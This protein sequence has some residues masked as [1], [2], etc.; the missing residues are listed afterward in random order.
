MTAP[1]PSP[2]ISVLLVD[3]DE[4]DRLALK[5]ALARAELG[6]VDIVEADKAS[7]AFDAIASRSFDCAFF[8]YRLPDD[9]GVQLLRRV[10]AAGARTP[11]VLLTGFGDEQIVLDAMKAGANDYLAK[12]AVSPERIGQAVR[13]ALRLRAAER[14][15]EIAHEAQ[16]RNAEQLRRLADAA[17][18]VNSAA[19]TSAMLQTAAIHACLITSAAAATVRLSPEAAEDLGASNATTSWY[20]ASGE[21]VAACAEL[22][23]S[24]PLPGRGGADVGELML[25][26]WPKPDDDAVIVGQLARLL[27][28][29]LEN[30]RLYEAAQRATRARDD[31]LA[32]VSHDLRNPLH[33]ISLSSSFLAEILGDD[34]AAVARQQ[35]EI[36]RRAVDRA[37]NL[38][39]DL[40]DVSRMDAGM[41]SVDAKATDP[42]GL[43]DEVIE[44][45]QPVAAESGVALERGSQAE[46][47]VMADHGRA[48]QVFMNLV[49]NAIK[50]TRRGGSVTLSS[51]LTRDHS[52]CFA[53]RDT[54]VGISAENLPHIFDRFWQARN[55][56]RAGAGLGLAIAK[57]IVEAHGGSIDVSSAPGDGTEFSFTLPVA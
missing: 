39:Q 22:S 57:G 49:G 45:M 5:R 37:N 17:V 30:V 54:G 8:D 41:F 7:V 33:T 9:D 3:D 48:L 12:S 55:A 53:V 21:C 52:V 46:A 29:A 50:F 14:H 13:A 56:T 20:A 2:P 51:S 1:A 36:I 40:L 35:T 24:V 43:I 27:A 15:A 26:R 10:R 11:V 4:I 23:V 19:E 32:V 42:R 47:M 44:T 18:A 31:V 38:I 16:R 28:G 34:A 6:D 25:S